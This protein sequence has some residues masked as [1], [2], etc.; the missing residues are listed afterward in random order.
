MRN[1]L[2]KN[3]NTLFLTCALAFISIA[4]AQEFV[5]IVSNK[6]TKAKVFIPTIAEVHDHLGGIEVKIALDKIRIYF[7]NK[8]TDFFDDNN[9]VLL[10]H[11][12]TFDGAIIVKKAGT[13]KVSYRVSAE[14]TVGGRP[15]GTEYNLYLNGV[16]V[17]G[18]YSSALHEGFT[19]KDTASASMILVL[20]ANDELQVKGKRYFGPSTVTTVVNGSSLLVERIR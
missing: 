14:I 16:V 2:F 4:N 11:Y 10:E 8:S 13:Y 5:H 7:R 15:S 17:D 12:D 3:V 6:G 19:S 9:N 1:Y 18:S 20:V